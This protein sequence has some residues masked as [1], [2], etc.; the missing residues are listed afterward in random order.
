MT[1]IMLNGELM[2]PGEARIGALDAAVQH[3]VG[4]FE[5]MLATRGSGGVTVHDLDAHLARLDRSARELRLSETLNLSALADDVRRAADA[6]GLARAR[7]RLTVTGGDLNLLRSD[8]PHAPTVLVVAQPA[9]EYPGAMFD[10]GVG[11][12]IADARANPFNPAEGHKTVSY[13]WRLRELQQAAAR[14]ASEALVFSITN[15]AVG[16]C[17]SNVFAVS[18]DRLLTPIARS[19]EAQGGLPSPVLPGITR[20]RVLEL[21]RTVGLSAERRMLTIDDLLHADELFLTNS[22]WAVL[23]VVAVERAR[24]GSGEPGPRT[25]ELL[26]ALCPQDRGLI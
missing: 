1:T 14:G 17:V 24:I 10:Q 11:V 15:H 20:A 9:P 26:R 2:D 6:S 25:G 12:V 7:V 5:T 3:A 16:G 18:G 22:S 4:L 19:E 8:R 23:P 21:A 13:W